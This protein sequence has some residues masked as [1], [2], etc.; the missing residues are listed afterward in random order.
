MQRLQPYPSGNLLWCVATGS[1]TVDGRS[2][3]AFE[4]IET[5]QYICVFCGS[6]AGNRPVYAE[7]AIALGQAIVARGWGIV[8]GGGRVGMMGQVA[9][10]ALAVGGTVI[11]V[12]PHF[13]HEKEIAH[14][15]LTE[16]HIV[17]SMH[18]RK[19]KMAA[20]ADA[21][22][23]LPGGYGTLE[24]F[25][26]ILTWAQLGIHNKPIG[27]LNVE[28]YFSSLLS[29][30]DLAVTEGFLKPPT[31]RHLVV[32]SDDRETLLDRLVSERP[33]LRS[34]WDDREA[35]YQRL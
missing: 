16:L 11:G 21:F 23:A 1:I 7:S 13:L 8:Y 12:I 2:D 4:E 19:A 14:P 31:L 6:S 5:L 26:E 24:E 35:S 29:F 15:G 20:L 25:C 27:L 30:F 3:R 17:E 33:P 32:E 9:D 34:K 22:V 18:E 10:A 28:G